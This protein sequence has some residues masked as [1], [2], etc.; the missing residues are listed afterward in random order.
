MSFDSS[1][2]ETTKLAEMYRFICDTLSRLWTTFCSP[3]LSVPPK[4]LHLCGGRSP[5]VCLE[6]HIMRSF[7]CTGIVPTFPYLT[8]GLGISPFSKILT[9]L[10]FCPSLIL[11]MHELRKLLRNWFLHAVLRYPGTFEESK[12]GTSFSYSVLPS[13]TCLT[14]SSFSRAST[15]AHTFDAGLPL[16]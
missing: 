4:T 12:Q 14:T 7:E 6:H 15:L 5:E 1:Q 9:S 8:G 3:L 10:A 2:M 16:V 13:R 11:A